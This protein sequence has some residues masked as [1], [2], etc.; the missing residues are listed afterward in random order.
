MADDGESDSDFLEYKLCSFQDE[1]S[2]DGIKNILL[3]PRYHILVIL[4]NDANLHVFRASD[5]RQQLKTVPNIS[6][7]HYDSNEHHET[8]LCMHHIDGKLSAFSLED[9]LRYLFTCEESVLAL[10]LCK[11]G[12]ELFK[13]TA[14]Y[15]LGYAHSSVI[16][17]TKKRPT[18]CQASSDAIATTTTLTIACVYFTSEASQKPCCQYT[19]VLSDQFEEDHIVPSVQLYE[20]TISVLNWPQHTLYLYDSSDGV[21]Y[22]QVDLC[23]VVHLCSSMPRFWC[24]S[25]DVAHLFLITEINSAICLSLKDLY[26]LCPADC[27]FFFPSNNLSQD[28][29]YKKWIR[30]HKYGYCLPVIQR[31]QF[32]NVSCLGKVVKRRVSGLKKCLSSATL[33]EKIKVVQL[34]EFLEQHSVKEIALSTTSAKVLF[35]KRDNIDLSILWLCDF[36]TGNVKLKRFKK[37]TGL[38]VLGMEKCHPPLILKETGIFAIVDELHQEEFV[39]KVMTYG[40]AR[41]TDE[42]CQMNHWGRCSLPLRALELGLKYR[43]IDTVTIFLQTRQNLFS[44]EKKTDGNEQKNGNVNSCLPKLQALEPAYRLLL[45]SIE[46]NMAEQQSLFFAQQ[47]LGIMLNHLYSVLNDILAFKNSLLDNIALEVLQETESMTQT[48]LQYIAKVRT[49]MNAFGLKKQ[50]SLTDDAK[51]G[52][53]TSIESSTA[54]YNEWSEMDV[55]DAIEDSIRKNTVPIVQYYLLQQ[56][57]PELASLSEVTRLGLLQGIKYLMNAKFDEASLLLSNLGYK[58]VEKYWEFALYTNDCLLRDCILNYFTETTEEQQKLITFFHLLQQTYPCISYEK[59][60]EN[61]LPLNGWKV[62]DAIAACM[63]IAPSCVNIKAS[64]GEVSINKPEESVSPVT[65][66]YSD[67]QLDWLLSWSYDTRHLVILDANMTSQAAPV[68]NV[69]PSVMWE[70][71]VSHNRIDAALNWLF[72]HI[73]SKKELVTPPDDISYRQI[74]HIVKTHGTNYLQELVQTLL[75]ANGI[76]DPSLLTHNFAMFLHLLNHLKGVLKLPSPITEVKTCSIELRQFHQDMIAYC[77][78]NNFGY[79]LWKYCQIHKISPKQLSLQYFESN[80]DMW[81]KM[82]NS[83]YALSINPYDTSPIYEASLSNAAVV[84]NLKEPSVTDLIQEG[85]VLAALATILYGND[86]LTSMTASS[87]VPDIFQ[88]ID[89]NLLEDS[90]L[91]YPRLHDALFPTSVKKVCQYDITVYQLMKGNTPFDP[92]WLYGWQNTNTSVVEENLKVMP[93]FS[94]PELVSKYAQH[95]DIDFTYYLR[96]G[97][98][99]FAFCS[100]LTDEFNHGTVIAQHRVQ[101]ACQIATKLAVKYFSQSQVSASCAAFVEMLGVDSILLRL[102]VN[103]GNKIVAYRMNKLKSW[104]GSVQWRKDYNQQFE[105]ETGQLLMGCLKRKR[106]SASEL[107]NTL[108]DATEYDI[109]KEEVSP[110]GFEAGHLWTQS[111]LLCYHLHLPYSTRF[112]ENCAKTNNWLPFLWF[113]QLHQYPKDQL[114]QLVPW[115]PSPHLRDHIFYIV[116]NAQNNLFTE[117]E[118]TTTKTDLE[119]KKPATKAFRYG[120]YS[121]IGV[122]SDTGQSSSDEDDALIINSNKE[123]NKETNQEFD[124]NPMSAPEDVFRVIFSAQA[125]RS[126]WKSLLSYGIALRNPLFTE[127]AACQREANILSCL[128][129]WLIA[130][131]NDLQHQHFL[132]QHVLPVT[133]W[134]LKD[135]RELTEIFIRNKWLA[136]LTVGFA[137]FQTDTPMAFFLKFL[138]CC[139][140]KYDYAE[141]QIYL[142]SFKHSVLYKPSKDKMSSINHMAQVFPMVGDISWQEETCQCLIRE[143]LTGLPNISDVVKL[144]KYLTQYN[145]ISVFTYQPGLN[146]SQLLQ[147]AEILQK[148]QLTIPFSSFLVKDRQHLATQV[149]PLVAEIVNKKLYDDARMLCEFAD[150]NHEEITFTEINNEKSKLQKSHCWLSEFIRVNFWKD[151]LAK[152]NRYGVSPMRIVQFFQ[153]EINKCNQNNTN[154]N[155]QA[156]MYELCVQSLIDAPDPSGNLYANYINDLSHKMWYCRIMAKVPKVERIPSLVAPIDEIFSGVEETYPVQSKTSALKTE[157][158]QHGKM[159][160]ISQKQSEFSDSE[161][162]AVSLLIG[163]LLSEAHLSDCCRVAAEFSFYSQ[164]L[165]IILTC[166]RLSIGSISVDEIAP[167]IKQ[168]LLE[169][170]DINKNPAT[171]FSRQFNNGTS[172][173]RLS[174]ASLGSLTGVGNLTLSPAQDQLISVMEQLFSLCVQ[175]KECCRRVLI[176][177]KIALILEKKYEFVITSDEFTILEMLLK[178]NNNARFQLA[179]EFL[180]TSTVSDNQLA[181]FLSDAIIKSLKVCAPELR[182]PSLN[183]PSSVCNDLI[184]NPIAGGE[185][186][187]ILQLCQDPS[188]LG[189]RLLDAVAS[190]ASDTSQDILTVQTNMLILA[191]HCHTSACNMEGISNV[192]RAA[193][194]LNQRLSQAEEFNLMISL[195][196]GVGRFNEMTYIF[197]ALKQHH[198]FELLMRK[199]MEKEDQLRSAILDYLKRF[200]PNDS[201]SYTMVALN[202]TM[203]R[204]IGQML[205][206]LAQK[207]LD[208]LKRKPLVNSSEVVLLLQKIHQYFSD[209]AKS[210][211]KDNILRHAEYCVRQARLLLL[212]MDLLP[213]GIHVINLTPEEATNFIK[214]HPK[215]SEALIVSEAYNRNAVWSEALCNRIIIHGD[216]RY[217]QDLKAYIRLNPSLIIDTIDR[218]KQMTQKP[219]QCLD[220]IKKLLTHCKDIRLQYQLGKELELKDF[221]TQLE[222]GS[223]S[224]YILDLEALRGSSHFSF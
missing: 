202:F 28:R 13:S 193:R 185:S 119:I 174:N 170:A 15:L 118:E 192:L 83:F 23:S 30:I 53:C 66:P 43:Q 37:E 112:L 91:H 56:N 49:Y 60:K 99:T 220:N 131:M 149:E 78:K 123:E 213:A 101:Y 81:M 134:N 153:D 3:C 173:F 127:L 69:P 216:F 182:S 125:S 8:T 68:Q 29:E 106:N 48:V 181:G 31:G 175:G 24:M 113:A 46:D 195:L 6:S 132:K 140:E 97:R 41:F 12:L 156:I 217:L 204:E 146:Y 148:N 22:L 16:L 103:I 128:C 18:N 188:Q 129:G 120:F 176:A 42:L 65:S 163:E 201:D 111:I 190:L 198:Q 224:A 222:D 116:N 214:E 180:A 117:T 218:Y 67:V 98:P 208:I 10:V 96:Q 93:H 145:I 212:Q 133:K 52:I 62:V 51:I 158:L 183:S 64:C 11:E 126:V 76:L 207:N 94:L 90:L 203:F 2:L 105:Q 184:F 88:G 143:L 162:R 9:D 165:A 159:P 26:T 150:I 102:L 154:M 166:I 57:S 211:M 33:D 221:I 137:I 38:L 200:H 142:E 108:E 215:F 189:N 187:Q 177:K 206:E 20:S 44:H 1:L 209:A 54:E 85:H 205:E 107:L 121:K 40:G 32:S 27:K 89:M 139:L 82:F 151:C 50:N 130:V 167:E 223:N 74:F 155:E 72:E 194:V 161:Q 124:L 122:A 63:S 39:D 141:A 199:G 36:T 4:Y 169:S 17:L 172:F 61:I 197:D 5:T 34:P 25:N 219:P 79:L 160:N 109:E 147:V 196:T 87:T 115:F 114:L 55:T 35:S 73:S 138:H 75:A 47:L 152:F 157:L 168:L 179:K 210:Y 71:L 95:E 21:C 19:I 77:T 178:V 164:D 136:N 84:W 135:L 7:I 110:F 100:F 171:K 58:P 186:Y 92:A 59:A 80:E 144:L 70:Y 14:P 104:G 45:Q 86:L 191:H